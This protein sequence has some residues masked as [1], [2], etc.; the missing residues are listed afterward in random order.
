MNDICSTDLLQQLQSTG[1][2]TQTPTPPPP[3]QGLRKPDPAAYAAVTTALALPPQRLI[4]VDDRKVNTDAAAALG[5]GAVHF[6]GAAEL[7]RELLA[8][9][10]EF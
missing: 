6:K 3:K 9:G 8:R 5:W 7:E 2:Q 1:N 10:L 4:F